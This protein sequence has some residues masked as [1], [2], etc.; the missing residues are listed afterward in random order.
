MAAQQEIRPKV[1][2]LNGTV[3]G[4]S[5][6]ELRTQNPPD[7][8]VLGRNARCTRDCLALWPV[9]AAKRKRLFTRAAK[10]ETALHVRS[11]IMRILSE[12]APYDFRP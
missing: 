10:K 5:R 11:A 12:V 4:D 7:F 2:I 6:G 1:E 3:A 8:T 9:C